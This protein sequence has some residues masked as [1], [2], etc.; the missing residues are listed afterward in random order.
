MTRVELL[1]L[2]RRSLYAVEA[3]VSAAR[4]PQGAVV[5]IVVTDDFE[6][7]AGL[8]TGPYNEV[9]NALASSTPCGIWRSQS[10]AVAKSAGIAMSRV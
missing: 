7:R 1:A 5:G 4:E 2:M 6:P 9:K 10:C 8:K 3:T